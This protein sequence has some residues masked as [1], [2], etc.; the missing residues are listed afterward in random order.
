MTLTEVVLAAFFLGLAGS[1]HCLGMCGA[2]SVNLSFSLPES[3]RRAS[4]LLYWHLL[5][6][7]GRVTFY[8]L[9][10]AFAGGVGAALDQRAPMLGKAIMLLS[11]LVLT[12]IALQ[13]F[14]Q[15]RGLQWLESIGAV[16]WRKVQPL[17]R[18]LLPL[19]K[20]W[21]AYLLGMLWGL[22]PC[23]L[24]YSAAALAAGAG[25]ALK[26][27]LLMAVFGLLTAIPVAGTGV[28]AGTLGWLRRPA[29]KTLAALLCL[30]LALAIAWQAL[31]GGHGGGHAGHAA[32]AVHD[33]PHSHHGH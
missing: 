9:L 13:L 25:S 29:W 12:L 16:V 3:E 32:P 28:L 11:A 18:P 31:S 14:G 15:A 1:T 26:G 17:T 27:A 19:R 23:G 30:G 8:A 10:G 33:T 5:V 2:I 21:Q 6:N 4:R 22:M 24:I 20:G 7:A